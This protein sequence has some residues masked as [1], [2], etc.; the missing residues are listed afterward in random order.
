MFS[1][2]ITVTFPAMLVM[3]AAIIYRNVTAAA[4]RSDQIVKV[5]AVNAPYRTY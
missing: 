2:N 5:T 3:T 4:H 1:F